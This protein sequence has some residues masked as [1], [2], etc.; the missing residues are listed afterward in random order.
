MIKESGDQMFC[1][2]KFQVGICLSLF[3]A[4]LFFP[5]HLLAQEETKTVEHE[6][7]FYYTVQKGDTLWDLSD[8]FSDEPWFWPDLWKE[9]NQIA[10][11]HWIYPGERIRLFHQKA[12]Q[13][14]VVKTVEKEPPPPPKELPYYY[15]SPI[16]KIGFIKK[17]PISPQGSIFKVKGDKT[18]IST[19]DLVYIKQQGDQPLALGSKYTVY[20]TLKP[21]V[22]KKTK[23]LIGTQHYLTGV[24]EITKKEPDFALAKVVRSFRT[25]TINDLLMPYKERSPKII[26]VE[27]EK[28]LYGKILG[29]EEQD[30]IMG[31]TTVAFIDKGQQDG[32]KIGQSYGIFYQEKQQ[33]DPQD[34]K[35]VLLTPVDYGTL[36]V[37]HTEPTTSTVLITNSEQTVYPGATFRSPMQ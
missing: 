21:L 14:Y 33:I 10:N 34:K 24:I 8:R 1:N 19:D 20:R 15:Y 13:S 12:I 2:H 16:D 27:S 22:E 9:N 31:E 26:L 29:T 28:G 36:L 32:V 7:G 30:H 25:I 23:M 11:P 3:I 5:Y 37:L 6:A 18:M 35:S 4:M 17:T